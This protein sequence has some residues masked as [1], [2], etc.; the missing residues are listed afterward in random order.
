MLYLEQ[1]IASPLLLLEVQLKGGDF[2]GLSCF[3]S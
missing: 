3:V 2:Y 1:V